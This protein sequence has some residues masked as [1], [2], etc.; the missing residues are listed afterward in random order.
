MFTVKF[1]MFHFA[2]CENRF[3]FRFMKMKLNVIYKTYI[4]IFLHRL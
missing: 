4:I 3:F 1:Q 2:C